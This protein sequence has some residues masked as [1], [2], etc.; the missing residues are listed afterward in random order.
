MK[1]RNE[2]HVTATLFAALTIIGCSLSS[3]ICGYKRRS[4]QQRVLEEAVKAWEDEGGAVVAEKEEE[5][6]RVAVL[7]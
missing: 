6:D 2:S 5:D 4:H 3:I 7:K 1:S